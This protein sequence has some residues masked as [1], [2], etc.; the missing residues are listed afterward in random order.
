MNNTIFSVIVT[1]NGIEWI[2]KCLRSLVLDSNIVVVDNDS[3]DGTQDLIE[4]NFSMVHLIKSDKNLG[5]GAA[6]NIG[7]NYALEQGAEYVFLLNQDAW[8]KKGTLELLVDAL[9]KNKEYGVMSPIHLNGSG[10]MLDKYFGEY[11]YYYGGRKFVTDKILERTSEF[12]VDIDFVNA[13]A[14]LLSRKCIEKVGLFD[15]L[16]FHYG[17]DDNYL[18]RVRYYSIKIGILTTA[19]I[20]HDREGNFNSHIKNSFQSR[21]RVYKKKW[22]NVNEPEIL[23]NDD[24]TRLLN[25]KTKK[26]YYSILKF[27]FN[28]VKSLI[29][30][31]KELKK[32][33]RLSLKSRKKNMSR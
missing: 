19:F 32:V 21:L 1:Y 26:I 33:G 3:S 6:N 7:I 11:L 27:N 30:E 25:S 29:Y 31:R 9:E 10:K 5:F 24:I 16:F 14:W 28:T 13:A 12:I 4:Q 15:P 18:Q 23:I 2:E 17:E 8:I 22:A 20:Y